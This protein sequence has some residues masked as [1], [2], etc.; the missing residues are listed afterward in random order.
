MQYNAMLEQVLYCEQGLSLYKAEVYIRK[1][2]FAV[3]VQ[4]GWGWLWL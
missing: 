3:H 1:L 4:Q 2:Y